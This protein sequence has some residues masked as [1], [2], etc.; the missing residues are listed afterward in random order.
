MSGT[1]F[2]NEGQ[3]SV[4]ID[5]MKIEKPDVRPNNPQFSSGPCAKQSTWTLDALSNAALGRSHRA[6]IG[7]DKLLKAIETTREVLKIPE[8]YKI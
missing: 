2:P 1:P 8:N 7:K 3:L 5:I 6:K 4:R